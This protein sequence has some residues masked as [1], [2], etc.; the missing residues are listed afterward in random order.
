MSTEVHVEQVEE[1]MPFVFRLTDKGEG[2]V[3]VDVGDAFELMDA[4][5][6]DD[7]GILK[8]IGL[9]CCMLGMQF[10]G[11]SSADAKMIGALLL[12]ETS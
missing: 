10:L 5:A 12:K 4:W 11:V 8:Q 1:A 2:D 6:N 7:N 9:R 3:G